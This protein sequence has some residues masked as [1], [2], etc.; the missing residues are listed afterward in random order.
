MSRLVLDC[1]VSRPVSDQ[2]AQW[3]A[4]SAQRAWASPGAGYY[5]GKL[6]QSLLAE[7]ASTMAGLLGAA[8]CWFTADPPR[9]V[10]SA[11]DQAAARGGFATV[12]TSVVDTTIVQDEVRAAAKRLGLRHA[13]VQVDADGRI[14]RAGLALLDGPTVLATALGNQEI[15]AVQSDL[16]QWA[17]RTG[18]AIV[19]DARCALGWIDLPDYWD[20]LI[21][22]PRAWGAPAGAA[23][24]A[25]RSGSTPR[26]QLEFENVAA[27]VTGVLCAQQWLSQAE[28]ARASARRQIATLRQRLSSELRDV[29]IHGGGPDD[30]PHILSVS[31][32]YVDAEA[33]Q[34]GLDTHGYAVG[35]GSACASRSGQPSHVLAGIGGLT[36]GNVRIG[37]PPGLE[38]ASVDGFIDAAVEVVSGVRSQMGTEDL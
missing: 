2:A 20:L 27:A 5:E 37:L 3:L 14:D 7:S 10:T 13:V 35:S 25:S 36:S 18:S 11:L 8:T 6:A 15:G 30:L 12:A 19:L 23:V 31:V 29:Q 17:A 33:V 9:A 16:G 21:L 34:N 32:L 22:D 4:T 28:G 1:A 26:W 38:D 24:V